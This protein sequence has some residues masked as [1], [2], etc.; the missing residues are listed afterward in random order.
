MINGPKVGEIWAQHNFYYLILK[1]DF[2]SVDLFSFT[3][4]EIFSSFPIKYFVN[5]SWVKQ[6]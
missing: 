3:R 5:G 4:A 2:E 1:V 6:C